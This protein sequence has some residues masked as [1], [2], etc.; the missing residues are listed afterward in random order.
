MVEMRETQR[1]KS[2]IKSID[3]IGVQFNKMKK[4]IAGGK[5]LGKYSIYSIKELKKYIGR[6]LSHNDDVPKL[7]EIIRAYMKISNYRLIVWLR[8]CQ[9]LKCSKSFWYPLA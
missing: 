6:D 2:Q 4:L 5:N 8:I 9:Y 1:P 3:F 7:K